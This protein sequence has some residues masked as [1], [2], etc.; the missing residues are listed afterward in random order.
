MK[1]LTPAERLVIAADFGPS[2][3]GSRHVAKKVYELIDFLKET[4]VFLKLG[5]GLRA[6]GYGFIE[7]LHLRG[8]KVFADLKLF[9]I[10]NTLAIEGDALRKVAPEIVTVSA[11]ANVHALR[12]LKD[13]L[14]ETEVLGVTVPTDCDDEHCYAIYGVD[15]QT[16]VHRLAVNAHNAGLDGLVVSG[17]DIKES[18]S[19]FPEMSINAVA[20]RPCWYMTDEHDDQHP[21]C[22]MAVKEAIQAGAHRVII[23][24]PITRSKNPYEAVMKIIEEIRDAAENLQ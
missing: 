11:S 17:A 18:R 16:S 9:D 24:R 8:V 22:V 4:E 21:S 3:D 1:T 6:I 2:S 20:I 15:R 10:Q 12:A 19:Y 5:S 14:P 13:A 7:D 23:G